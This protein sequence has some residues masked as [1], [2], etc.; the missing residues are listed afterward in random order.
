MEQDNKK[1]KT[2]F[3]GHPMIQWWHPTKNGTLKPSQV[4]RFSSK[5]IFFH[6]NVCG[7]S[8]KYAPHRILTDNLVCP[9]CCERPKFCGNKDCRHCF[10]QS[11][12][13][14]KL[15]TIR[16]HIT[17][18]LPTEPYM[19]S[20]ASSQKY[21]FW[22]EVCQHSFMKT[23]NQITGQKISGCPYCASNARILCDNIDCGK[24]F[25]KSLASANLQEFIWLTHKNTLT[26]RQVLK[27]STEQYWFKCLKCNHD[28][29]VQVQ[30]IIIA[31]SCQ[32]C[33][34]NKHHCGDKSCQVCRDNS[35]MSLDASKYLS[36]KNNA[37]I[38]MLTKKSSKVAIFDCP[39]CDCEYHAQ[40]CS[41]Y[42]GHWCTCRKRKSETKLYNFLCVMFPDKTIEK[43][44]KF[45]WCKNEI[46]DRFL[47]FDFCIDGHLICELDG[48]QH[49]QNVA[50]WKDGSNEYM[51]RQQRDVYKMTVAL[52]NGFRFIRVFQ[53]DVWQDKNNWDSNLAELIR[54]DTLQL[55]FVQTNNE[56]VNN[57]YELYKKQCLESLQQK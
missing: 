56:S 52:Q 9:Y 10:I 38:W 4:T 29:Y 35:I 2:S 23:P 54:N 44:V 14:V 7:H 40:V 17:L 12:A 34:K 3:D 25:D 47:P 5:K 15:E 53:M 37:D 20:K 48:L 41:V 33:R 28:T 13:S 16:W 21:Y 11:F 43:N 27:H 55:S 50:H 19:V 36:L 8:F 31:A 6:H 39:F 24:C 46:S 49:F 26:M 30:S 18:N 22:H 51:N 32:Y 45:E 42:G 57:T 1:I